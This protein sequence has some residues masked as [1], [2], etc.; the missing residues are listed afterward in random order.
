MF[1]IETRK[2]RLYSR[3]ALLAARDGKHLI[4]AT[5]DGYDN[6]MGR[7]RALVARGAL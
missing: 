4:G 7:R 3:M 6:T 2:M 5:V 1:S